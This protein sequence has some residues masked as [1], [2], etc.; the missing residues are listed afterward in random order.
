MEKRY[1]FFVSHSYSYAILRP[2][3]RE[4]WRRGHR[5]AWFLED[6]CPDMLAEGEK[7]LHTIKEVMTYNPVVVFAPGNWVYDFFPGVKVQVFHGYPINKR[8]DKFDDH[9]RIRGWFDVYC[10]QGDSSTATFR[11]LER[12]YR[13]F[14]VYETGW[15]KADSF[16]TP[17]V[18]AVSREGKKPT[19]FVATTFSKDISSLCEF[20]P[21]I[22][23]LADEKDWNW[24]ITLHPKLQDTDL[25]AKF[26]K[27]A[28]SHHNIDFRQVLSGVE[29]MAE[30][31][32][33]LCDSSSIIIE[34]MLLDKPVVTYRN[35]RPGKYLV[36]VLDIADVVPALEYAM[37]RPVELMD[38][39]RKYAQWHEHYRDGKNCERILDAVDDFM[40]N[41][42]G[43]IGRKPLNLIRR[44]KLRWKLWRK[45]EGWIK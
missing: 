22:K 23:R 35:T 5:T 42:K 36:N 26:T 21:L 32:V 16:F 38:N 20:Y 11:E 9:F 37:K 40:T 18:K 15:C 33:L 45:G 8:N 17:E 12:K 13:Y 41:H 24:I 14:K 1:L 7:R 28:E 27:L 31:D 34:Y 19:V 3:Q 39:I 25:R 44:L 6:T 43:R 10:T 30:S 2:L 4:I 29:D